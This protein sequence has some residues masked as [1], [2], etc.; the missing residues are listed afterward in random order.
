[1]KRITRDEAIA[2]IDEEAARTEGCVM[3]GT[4]RGDR[5]SWHRIGE[6]DHAVAVLDRLATT[7]G[8]T[9]VIAKRHVERIGAFS[10]DEW[11]DLQRLV[12]ETTGRIEAALEPT[13]VYVASLGSPTALRTTFP[14]VHVHLVP[15]YGTEDRWRPARVFTW[16]E[17][18]WIYD[19][20]EAEALANT[21]RAP[22]ATAAD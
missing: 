1:M 22:R 9:L 14:H 7:R 13:R 16:Q 11:L 20:A 15:I 6:S 10:V 2:W 3:C 18:V 17:G 21:L 8:H 19:D 5:P 12:L 4:A